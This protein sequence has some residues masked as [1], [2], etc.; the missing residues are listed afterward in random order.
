M[1][2]FQDFQCETEKPRGRNSCTASSHFPP[3]RHA[4]SMK[5]KELAVACNGGLRRVPGRAGLWELRI[6]GTSLART[7]PEAVPVQLLVLRHTLSKLLPSD[8]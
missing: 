6:D 1:K 3:V 5:V 4:V 8:P 2:S 7:S